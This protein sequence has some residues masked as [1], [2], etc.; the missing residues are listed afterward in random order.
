MFSSGFFLL[1]GIAF[2]MSGKW[3]VL[4]YAVSALIVVPA[5]LSKAELASALPKAGGTY[6][7]LDRS[8]GPLIGTV[9]GL[10]TWIA[11]GLKNTFA[12]I[13]LGAYLALFVEVDIMVV[14]LAGAVAFTAINIF[15]AKETAALQRWLVYILVGILLIFV[16][17]GFVEIAQGDGFVE[18]TRRR[19]R[20]APGSDVDGFLATVGLVFVSYAGLTKVAG[21]AE[22]VERPDRN[23]LFG[24]VL[25]LGTAF[26]LYTLGA[27]VL[28]VVL[29]HAALPTDLAPIASAAERTLDWLPGR[30]G[31]F[32]IFLAA[33]AAFASTANAGIL[34]A[35]RYLLAMG[36][37]RLI[38]DAFRKVGRFQ[39]PTLAI[40]ATGGFV[41]VCLLTLDV[42]SVA[43][44][45]SSFQLLM[46]ALVCLAVIVMRESRIQT[47]DPPVRSPFYPWTQ[48]AG[49]FVSFFLIIEMGRLAILFTLAIVAFGVVWFFLYAQPRVAREGAVLHWFERLGRDRSEAL[50]HEIW[51]I[52]KETGLRAGDPFAELMSRTQVVELAGRPAFP[53]VARLVGERLS[54]RIPLDA[55]EIA[56]EFVRGVRTGLVPVTHGIA[57]PHFRIPG[58]A[59]HELVVARARSGVVVHVGEEHPSGEHEVEVHALFFL[60]SPEEEPGQHLRILAKLATQAERPDFLDAWRGA[61]DAGDLR[62][63]L[64]D[65]EI[66]A[67]AER[68]VVE[69][70]PPPEPTP[71]PHVSPGAFRRVLV[72]DPGHGRTDALC[73]R[74]R[75]LA[76]AEEAHTTIARIS[77]G[78]RSTPPAEISGPERSVIQLDGVPWM[79]VIREV[80]VGQHDLV[81]LEAGGEGVFDLDS[82]AK[83]LLRKCPCPVWVVPSAPAR[84]LRRVVAA[85]DAEASTDA[86]RSLNTFILDMA[87]ALTRDPDSELHVVY[88]WH[89]AGAQT[90]AI[91]GHLDDEA[92][93][94]AA[95]K[96]R[97][98]YE[99]KLRE[100][101]REHGASS[102]RMNVHLVE[103]EPIEALPRFTA[104]HEADV[105]VMGTVCR[106]GIA[107]YIIGNTA[108]DVLS[109]VECAVV[110]VKPGGFVTPVDVRRKA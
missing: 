80:V 96:E 37:D 16:F 43:K 72:I 99:H 11:L 89:F 1:P 92:L 64:T 58:L 60:L 6:Y 42:V 27:F 110:A 17:A 79:A 28:V 54:E 108:E 2:G 105:L 26:L 65:Q 56:E 8:M 14:A 63:L 107:G 44:L 84:A 22:E 25:S 49:I 109:E 29:D 88:A 83:H 24:M 15:G 61:R 46:F 76:T 23:I 32:L 91:R 33:T 55:V 97:S 7:F 101:L 106:T 34:A 36:R 10:G 86:H 12:L 30:T 70:A 35:S 77:Q 21:V 38:A 78:G 19:F 93:R 74:V 71:V 69:A 59:Q 62:A 50:E 95:W 104:E 41:V 73:A 94:H 3:V 52:L 53:E 39:T 90:L 9:G 51:S 75:M 85:I 98:Y 4:A 47:Y 102:D 48:L 66:R 87:A 40:L 81:L 82:F 45:A 100:V 18:T 67:L 31:V 103:G 57:I 20:E 5:M 68:V 13:G